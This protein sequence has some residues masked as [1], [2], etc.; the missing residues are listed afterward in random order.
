[1]KWLAATLH[2]Q[3]AESVRLEAEIKK[4]LKGWDMKFDPAKPIRFLAFCGH[5]C[6]TYP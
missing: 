1:M 2:Q 5:V 4:N 3:F 6:V